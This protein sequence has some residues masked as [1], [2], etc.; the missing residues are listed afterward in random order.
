MPTSQSR[1]VLLDN[2]VLSNFALVNRTEIVSNLWP[3]CSTTVDAWREFQSG[4]TLGYLPKESWGAL[5]QIELNELDQGIAQQFL[6]TLGAGERTCIAVAK[7]CDG[8]F[9]TDDRK[10]RQVAVEMG[11]KVTGTLGILVVAVERQFIKFSEAESLLAQMI[12]YGYR[13]PIDE[14]SKLFP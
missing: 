4:I 1:P 10:A 5:P 11:L 6:D 7:N 13:S 8:L 3:H 2:T 12:E 9:V 14:L